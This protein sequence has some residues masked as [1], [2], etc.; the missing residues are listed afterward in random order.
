[1]AS[2]SAASFGGMLTC[3][4]MNSSSYLIQQERLL[5][6]RFWLKKR[7][8]PVFAI[9]AADT[10]VFESAPG[11]LG[12]VGH[13]IDHD[14]TGSQ[15]GG[16]SPCAIEVSPQ[17]SGVETIFGVV[18]NADRFILGVVS[19]YAEHGAENLLLGNRHVVLHIDEDGRLYKESPFES[20]G[21]AFSADQYLSAFFDAFANVR[22][23]ALILFLRHHRSDHDLGI[24]RIA[25]CVVTHLVFDRLLDLVEPAFG[26]E[27]PRSGGT[28]LTTIHKG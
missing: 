6:N 13:G 26:H 8:N 23:H 20:L 17:D 21:T 5:K 3:L 24:G 9:F 10:G 2:R 16:H 27:K 7:L 12:I 1:M 19:Y 4:L 28:G 11:C 14:A 18:G 22:F 25:D 15:L